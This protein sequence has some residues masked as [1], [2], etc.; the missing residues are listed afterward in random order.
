MHLNG[1][2]INLSNVHCILF[3]NEVGL[4]EEFEI[5]KIFQCC[6]SNIKYCSID[7]NIL[8]GK[9]NYRWSLYF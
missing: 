7:S 4:L 1:C 8:L 2:V 9:V 3:K 5:F 6:I